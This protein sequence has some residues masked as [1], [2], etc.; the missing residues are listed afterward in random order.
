MMNVAPPRE[1]HAASLRNARVTF[2]VALLLFAA[3]AGGEDPSSSDDVV[4]VQ[5]ALGHASAT[6]TLCTY[7][8]L[9][10]TAEDKTRKAACALAEEVLG[11]GVGNLRAKRG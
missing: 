6:T 5:R 1:K 11:A 2:V 4:T 10:P 3:C 8:H 9:W 7:S